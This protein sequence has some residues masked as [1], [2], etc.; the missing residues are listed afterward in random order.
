MISEAAGRV[1]CPNLLNHPG[2]GDLPKEHEVHRGVRQLNYQDA[3]ESK[4]KANGSLAPP[5]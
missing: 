1:N 2:G 4:E 5:T 3:G